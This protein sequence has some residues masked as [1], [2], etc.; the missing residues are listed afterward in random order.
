MVNQ[1]DAKAA[2]LA[3]LS[4]GGVALVAVDCMSMVREW[5]DC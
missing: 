1:M 3:G 5:A 2:W 4:Q